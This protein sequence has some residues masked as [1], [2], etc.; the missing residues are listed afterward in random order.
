MQI[1]WKKCSKRWIVFGSECY[2][3]FFFLFSC[4]FFC[5]SFLFPLPWCFLSLPWCV[6]LFFWS[7]AIWIYHCLQNI[8]EL[9]GHNGPCG[10][11]KDQAGTLFAKTAWQWSE[12]YH[13]P[14][15]TLH[16]R[17]S[18]FCCGDTSHSSTEDVI[19]PAPWT[20]HANPSWVFRSR[21]Y[22]W[23]VC[24]SMLACV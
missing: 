4:L 18:C 17:N 24:T 16:H 12:D 10:D 20:M 13:L 6:T 21:I 8:R 1:N 23:S 19:L 5:F 22:M 14:L 11:G 7:P 3:C 9:S 2:G 15:I